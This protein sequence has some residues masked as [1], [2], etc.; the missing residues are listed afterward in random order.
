[1]N[2]YSEV[3]DVPVCEPTSFNET[4]PCVSSSIKMW[5]QYDNKFMA[6][7]QAVNQLIAGQYTILE[8][9]D[10]G[11][12]FDKK[13]VSTDTLIPLPDSGYENIIKTVD[14]FWTKKNRYD[15]LG[16]L[17]K[18]GILLWGPP[19]SGKTS[20][21]QTISQRMIE[22]NGLIIHCGNPRI[23]VNGLSILRKIEKNRQIIVLFEDIDAIVNNCGEQDIL[24][25]LDGESQIDNVIFIATTNYPERLDK[26]LIN[27]PGRFDLVQLIGMPSYK[28]RYQFLHSKLSDCVD[29]NVINNWAKKT[30]GYSIAH[31]KETIVS[32]QCYNV[33][34]NDVLKRISAMMDEEPSSDDYME[35]QQMGFAIST[36]SD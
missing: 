25:L 2:D 32:V 10:G 6:C 27:R 23:L 5:A 35:K 34:L 13:A 9:N 1:M 24:G 14:E 8:N 11:I 4:P 12:V 18:R 33:D 16:F 29:E 7:D 19:G 3:P 20:I 15:D 30:K 21:L 22:K 26:R 17:F 31:L 36:L 28:A